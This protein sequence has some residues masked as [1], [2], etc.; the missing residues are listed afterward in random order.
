MKVSYATVLTALGIILVGCTSVTPYTLPQSAESAAL[1]E[2]ISADYPAISLSVFKGRELVWSYS[3]GHISDEKPVDEQTN[4]N[5]FST[6]KALTGLA[7]ARLINDGVISLDTTVEQLAPDFPQIFYPI[8]L[9]DILSHRSGIRHYVSSQ[10]WLAFATRNCG[11]PKDAISYFS[12]DPLVS[13]PGEREHYSTFAYV[14]ASE[15]LVRVTNEA[16]FTDAL[17]KT[18]GPWAEFQLDGQSSNKIQSYVKAALLPQRPAGLDPNSI[19]PMPLLNHAC[20][21]GG[22]GLVMGSKALARAGA[23]LYRGEIIPMDRLPA[24]FQPLI[25]GSSIVYGAAYNAEQQSWELSGGAAGGRSYLYVD[26]DDQISVAIAG[27]FDGPN[28][29]ETARALADIW[30]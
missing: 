15:L 10:D 19:V 28:F 30:R 6:A 27:N 22:G 5:T 7:F 8:R 14:L 9:R 16:N 1:I 29:G 23:A 21:F 18:L 25:P 4:F 2:K 3:Q 17:N 11:S 13:Q 12:K 24:V 20:K 26:I